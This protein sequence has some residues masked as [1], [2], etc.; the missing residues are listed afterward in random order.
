[1]PEIGGAARPSA[2]PAWVVVA[3]RELRDVWVAGRGLPLMLAYTA[4]LS[5]TSY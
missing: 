5:V 4:M 1:M 2:S 3:E